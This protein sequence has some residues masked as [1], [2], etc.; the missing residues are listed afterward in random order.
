LFE[1]TYKVVLNSFHTLLH[2]L[3]GVVFSCGV[4]LAQ[5]RADLGMIELPDPSSVSS[6]YTYDPTTNRYIFSK[7]IGGYPIS[8]PLVL[9][10][11][12]FEALV[13]K[14]RM[15]RYFQEKVQALSG[16]GDNVEET[17]K[18]LL[19]ELYVNNKFFESIF[20]SSAIDIAP[21]GS[22]G[23]DLGYRYQRNDNPI[24]SVIN[25]RSPGFEFDQRISLSLLG[26]IGERLQITANYDTESTFDFQ[27]LV[28]IQFNPPQLSEVQERIPGML[29][30]R[31]G[32]TVE[33]AQ[34]KLGQVQDQVSEVKN[35][36]GQ[37]QEKVDQVKGLV[38]EG[39]NT[40]NQARQKIENLRQ[41]GNE[42]AS[43][44]FAAGNKVSEFLNGKVTEDAIL[45]NI[46]IGNISM[47]I[48]S[49]LIQGAQSLFGVRADLKFGNT[50]ISSVFSEQR[51][52]LQNITTQGGG[53]LQEFDLYA[54]D[55]EEDRH[56]F[57]S[58]YFRD[59]YDAF[60]A[61]YPYINSPVQITRIE[62]WVTNR[63]YQ[64]Q[65]VRNIIALQ[66]LGEANPDRT[67]L[68][69]RVSNFIS[70]ADPN[71]PPTNE[72]NRLDPD[73][74]GYDGLLTN[75]IRD[76]ATVKNGF[77]S[78]P[79]NE[80]YDYAVLES[81]RKLS[82]QEFTFHPQLGY[83]SLNQRLSNDEILG[84]A[85]QYSFQGRIYQVGE[86]A[87]GD[88][89]GTSL[90]QTNMGQ[91]PVVQTNNLIV[92][93]LKS[94]VTDVRQPMWDLMMKNIYNT[95]AFQL[96]EEDFRL[97]I[98]YTDPSPINYMTPVDP[99][100]WPERLDNEVLL[101]TMD[102]DRLN[103]YQDLVPYGDGFFDYIPG[104]TID[105][106]YGRII[107]PKVEPFGKFL[108][109]L[110][111][112][113]K[114]AKENY[115]K[116]TTYNKN[117]KRYVFREMYSLTK[118]AALEFTEKNK[119]QLKGRYKS[120]GGDGIN[121]GAF[122]VPR[123]SVRVTAGGRVLREGLDYI[124]NYEIGRVKILDEG[125]KASNIPIDISVE[126]NSFFNQ[127][128]KRFSGFNVNHR[129]SD[130]INIGGTLI[131]LSENP[132]TQKANYGTEPV[133]NTMMGLNT[134]FSTELP[135]L[136]RWVNKWPTI[137]TNT[138]SQLSFRGEMANLLANDPRN[139]QLNGE[140]NVYIDDFEGA[141]TTIDIKGF[142]AWNLSS[143]PV[144]GV[145]GATAEGLESGYGRSKL[146]W[147]SIDQVFYSRQPN[148]INNDDISSNETRRI[149][150][151]ELFP[152]QDLVQGT[153]RTL[154]TFDLA[155]YPDER[156]PYNN[157]PS[158]AYSSNTKEKWAGISRA[159]NATNFE[160]SN[161]E[162][163]EFWL[164]D[165]FSENEATSNELGELVF[166][167]GNISEDIL[168]D[169]RKQF[170]NGL[171]STQE[172][173]PTY[174]T[175][176][177]KVPANQSLVYAFNAVEEDRALQDVGLDGLAD[178]EEA[179]IF[180][181]GPPDD[182]AGDNYEYFLQASGGIL[183][184]Y[185][186]YNGFENNTPVAFSDTDRGNTTE[187]DTEDI[188]RDQSMNTIDSYF[189]YRIP[190]TKEMRVGNHPFVTDVRED[191]KV[192][193][194]NGDQYTTRW[195][196]FKVPIQKSYYENTSFDPYFDK[197]N[198]IDDLRSIRFM[199]MLLTG[200]EEKV[201]FR[202]GTLDLVRGD[203]R[204]YNK[205]LNEEILVHNNTTVD[206]STVNI[207]E[208]ENRIPINYVLP[209]E[210]QREQINNNNT[211]IRQNEQS[212]SFR[213][214]DLQPSDARGIFK[215]LD[216]DMRQYSKL[217]MFLHAESLP[218]QEALPGEGSEDEFDKRLVAF[219]RLGTDYQDNFYQ[220]EIPLKPTA[221]SENTSNRYSAE[222]VWNPESNSLEV[223][224]DLLAKLKA[225]AL[226]QLGLGETL[227]FD[228]ELNAIQEFSPISELPGSKKYKFAI[229]GNPSLGSIKTLM[230]GV[231]NP[232]TQLGEALCGEVWFNELRIS[233][234]D[235]QDGWA[236]VG[237]LDGN[238]ADFATFSATGRYS[239][240][241]F[242][243][244][245][246]TPNERTREELL[247][248]DIISNVNVGQLAPENWGLQIP[249]SFAT[250]ETL[251]TPEYDP[252]YQDIKL[253]DRLETAE[254]QS[255][256]DSIRNQSIDYTKR[257][258]VSLI[259]V[260]KNSNGGGKQRFYSP[261][262][263][264]FSYA[265]NESVHRDYEIE[266]QEE[267]ALL[268]GS[269]YGHS[270][271][272][273]PI[274]PFK[275]VD[276]FDRKKYLQ[277]LQQLNFNLLPSSVEASVNVNRI[278][279]NQKFR[280]VYLEGVDASLQRSLPN[281]QQRN[282]LFDYNYALSH[283][284]S[285]SLR[286]NFNAATSSIIRDNGLTE[287][288]G[289]NPFQPNKNA[290]WQGIL[291]T[292]EPNNHIQTFSM[293]YKLPF[294]YIPFLSFVDAVYN[295]T[296]NFN[297]QRGSEALSKVVSN[298][299]IPLGIVNTI[300]NNN[301]KTLT[302]AFSFSK[303]YS[304]LGL[305]SNANT[306]FNNR[307]QA[308][309]NANDSLSK[310]KNSLVKKGLT[311][312]V[313]LMTLV[314]RVQASY[315][316]NNGTVLP[317]YLPSVG[318]AGGLQPTLGY[319]L[320][321]QA[322]IRYE[323]AR[324][325]WLTGFPN[326]NQSF[327]QMH[328][329]KFKAN[330][331]LIPMKGLIID[332]SADRDYM[333]NRLE[334]FKVEEQTYI[335]RNSNV[336]G[337]FGTS[338]ILLKTAFNR[339]RG[340]QSSNF[341][342]FRAYRQPIAA[343][344]VQNTPFEGLGNDE[345]GYPLGYGK[346]QQEVLL[347]S[348]LAA[349]TGERP[350]Q[351]NLN[352][353]R[354]T[355]LPNWNLKYTGLTDFKAISKIFSRLSINHAYRASYTLTNFQSN[356]DYDPKQ[357]N[358]TDKLGNVISERLYSNVNLVE[359]FN[360]LLRLDMEM[361]NSLKLVAELRKERAISLSLDNSLIT[362]SSG[363]EYVAGLGYRVKDVRFRTSFGGRRVTLKGDLN[364]RADVSYRDN[365]TVL[366]NLEYD[367]NQVTAGQRILAI[368]INAD[369]ALSRNLT[370]LFFYDHNFSEFAI[371]TAFPQTSIRSGFTV[372]YNFGN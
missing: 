233:G 252:F 42:L 322:D 140:T 239:S 122:N 274:E 37:V 136:T 230:I 174:E 177:G 253:E 255:Q 111:D 50:T 323:A 110:L 314:K 126:N 64:T 330:A 29:P 235:S 80:G 69:E 67:T 357:P 366:R 28:K 188:N 12:E 139:T 76:I 288:V 319:T 249:L 79:V 346:S 89:P 78:T 65:N 23:I 184:R 162:F 13:L 251:I 98:L 185:K 294:E 1:R 99:S 306:P 309:K 214:C 46:D 130:K 120:E 304:A 270:I 287:A 26:K 316:E 160:Q 281:L 226:L 213:V 91:Q 321:S 54:L 276:F 88:I 161:V 7:E 261:E 320:G 125:L 53:K 114:S 268:L 370:A 267:F 342:N 68:D 200:F 224:I 147:Y 14:E 118:A 363:D 243:S 364:I 96:S 150:I 191:V 178:A 82:Q 354:G 154:P 360:P 137:K 61:T 8:T 182:P 173:T 227:Y 241:G 90:S 336:F 353:M 97:S 166:H 331:Q 222:E 326:F 66:D 55:Y 60:L 83:I 190:I 337:N 284:F 44:P 340:T 258:S 9:T 10:V 286:F 212:L 305:K 257:K 193:A 225:K 359:Q 149:F 94:S 133:N 86:F 152:E 192:N 348:F 296:G 341:E 21:Q 169:G 57:I 242:G 2:L 194:P 335:P 6:Q 22:I 123:G 3:I 74:I 282:F 196:Q 199:R 119:F 108:F 329:S 371:S 156:G 171:P 158:S 289:L 254:R 151:D 277:W 183:E 367:N 121:I 85:Y 20:G 195:I 181:N 231:K 113:P 153:P 40:L 198:A 164:L 180:T 206:I 131:N 101:N 197:I 298:D 15:Q 250:G 259:G 109:E 343:R 234:I 300:Q 33:D 311:K 159:L 269:N 127:Q 207:L 17:Q 339:A 262:N 51:S 39:K 167:L 347:N 63:G 155:Y 352:P 365:I 351:I 310:K 211:I 59:N 116:E 236:A 308:M 372:R 117:Q 350:E 146:A 132:L 266:N 265:Y 204:R 112:N 172:Q 238:V 75:A 245:D 41:T 186:R 313:D 25:R 312:L 179:A 62:V 19:P 332:F 157:A 297:W 84:I 106:R 228:E 32:S 71:S 325:G 170:E 279:N 128:N 349:Y 56:Y 81:A 210:I 163:I 327:S 24:A 105:P 368:K 45:Q 148:G 361:N 345:E 48:N 107:F 263:F 70:V 135:F 280:Q 92:K 293:N 283:N 302:T 35:R 295:Y 72:V 175:P 102:L 315:V 223:P 215:G 291:N 138:P 18:N 299:G 30:G 358:Q 27:N 275:K 205:P 36:I 124:V 4:V 220:I 100:I 292:G 303:L 272:S 240:I 333:Q 115:T 260:R 209:P 355:P 5:D 317:G 278:L 141:Q 34:R 219:I 165:T 318:F 176:W 271:A 290:L 129:V 285:K 47:P 31:F 217:R 142:T 144:E 38:N 43:N 338:T 52:Q 334:N 273:K 264:D 201:V 356:F 244:I 11:K 58:Q 189:E 143:V 237:A 104:I 307:I 328:S 369:Y 216:L 187:P 49:N 168:R 229:R 232:S 221:Y 256:R 344:L 103:A 248:Y 95:G 362:E 145:P 324:Q 87:N 93:M 301:T 77:G 202:F 208:N 16:R 218:G 73:E 246:M 203:W 134:N 247:Q